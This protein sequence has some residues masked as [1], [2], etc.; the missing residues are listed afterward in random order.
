MVL[1][2]DWGSINV[3]GFP[4]AISQPMAPHDLISS[5]VFIPLQRRIGSGIL[6]DSVE[7]GSFRIAWQ[8]C[9]SIELSGQFHS[10]LKILTGI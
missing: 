1:F 3:L 4:G 7:L 6:V 9:L 2:Q 8:V 5:I 10:Y